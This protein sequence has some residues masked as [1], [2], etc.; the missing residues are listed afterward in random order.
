MSSIFWIPI[1]AFAL[2]VVGGSIIGSAARG[3][4]AG[5]GALVGGFLALMVTFPL[6]AI[7]L[8]SV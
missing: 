5:T 6:L 4:S 2:G 3:S 1:G 7:G 8:A